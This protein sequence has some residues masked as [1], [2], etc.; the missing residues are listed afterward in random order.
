MKKNVYLAPETMSSKL[1]LR[2]SIIAGSRTKI[3]GGNEG[4]FDAKERNDVSTVSKSGNN[5]IT[6]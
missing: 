1:K 5:A 2:T 6:F 4:V 3:G